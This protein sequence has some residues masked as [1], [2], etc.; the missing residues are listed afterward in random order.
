MRWEYVFGLMA[1]VA[2]C[3]NRTT[4]QSVAL[5]V[6]VVDDQNRALGGA[7]V[8]IDEK[9]L[10][11][12]DERGRITAQLAG[13]EG[14]KLR[15]RV[16][17]PGGW[18]VENEE[19]RELYLRFLKPIDGNGDVLAPIDEL[20][21]CV[22]TTRKVVVLVRA[23]GRAGLRILAMGRELARTDADGVAQSVLEGIPGD[24]IEIA[25]DTSENPE[26][27]PA[28]PS[29]RFTMPKKNQILIFDQRFEMRKEDPRK[30]RRRAR[31]YSGPKRL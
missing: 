4:L 21:R 27:R 15:V 23:D 16:V 6:E 5:I 14:R 28:M 24:E 3:S 19:R 7:R 29:R 25:I 30:P 26:L 9:S 10:G 18:T 20:F 31:K 13:P 11:V 1:V 12:T 8:L 2:A 22:P 17:C